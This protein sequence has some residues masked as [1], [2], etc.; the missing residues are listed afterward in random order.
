M[1]TVAYKVAI[2]FIP[3]VFILLRPG[4]VQ[5]QEN[6][7]SMGKA[8]PLQIGMSI[9]DLYQRVGRENTKLLDAF[10]EGNFSPVIEIYRAGKGEEKPSLIVEVVGLCS[11]SAAKLGV[12][13]GSG[14]VVGGITVQDPQ[15]KTNLGIGVGSSLGEIRRWYK[16]D[17][18]T[19]GEGP[20]VARVDQIG[21]SFAL[22]YSTPSDEWYRTHDPVLI[23]DSARVT[24]IGLALPP[25][26]IASQRQRSN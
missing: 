11:A 25:V 6:T 13:Y 19:F 23:P 5:G 9:D 12:T 8:G 7:I 10:S 1:G 21:V 15:F 20:L 14:F 4:F 3:I 22:D 17:W 2:K 18:I 16:V 24:S 26:E